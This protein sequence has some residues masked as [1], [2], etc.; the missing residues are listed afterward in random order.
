M[1]TVK[2]EWKFHPKTL[3]IV[4]KI[5]RKILALNICEEKNRCTV[6]EKPVPSTS[7]TEKKSAT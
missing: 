3:I 1:F 4:V 7:T 5:E 2:R 6:V